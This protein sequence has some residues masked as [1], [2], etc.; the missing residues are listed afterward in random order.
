MA[1]GARWFIK[2]PSDPNHSTV[3]RIAVLQTPLWHQCQQTGKP[4][5]PQALCR[6]RSYRN[7]CLRPSTDCVL[8][9][10]QANQLDSR[11]LWAHLLRGAWGG[12]LTFGCLCRRR[13]VG[14]TREHSNAP[15]CSQAVCCRLPCLR[16]AI[17]FPPTWH[18]A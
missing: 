14:T 13:K 2:I 8:I 6:C 17:D 9:K 11:R 10:T 18:S 1:A 16:A 15:H 5:E 7:E 12:F 4:A 3:L